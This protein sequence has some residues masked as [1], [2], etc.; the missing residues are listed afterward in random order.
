MKNPKN[1][2]DPFDCLTRKEAL[3]KLRVIYDVIYPHS[4]MACGN[5]ALH[6]ISAFD[7]YLQIRELFDEPSNDWLSDLLG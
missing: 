2:N 4:K 6:R 1:E 5:R 7:V 3:D